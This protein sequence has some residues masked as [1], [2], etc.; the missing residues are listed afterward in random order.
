MD[1]YRKQSQKKIGPGGVKCPCCGPKPGKERR[2]LR[3]FARRAL[4]RMD[5]KA[6]NPLD[7]SD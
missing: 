3:R 2:A 6:F 5:R 1:A 7:K 4:R